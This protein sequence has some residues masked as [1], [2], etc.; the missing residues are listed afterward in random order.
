MNDVRP[1]S[2]E[3]RVFIINLDG[4]E[5]YYD[6]EKGEVVSRIE[7]EPVDLSAASGPATL[8]D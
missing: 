4:F 7:F 6:A 2:G 1:P 3:R 8:E 5:V